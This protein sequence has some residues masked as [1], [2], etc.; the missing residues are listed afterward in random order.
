MGG[1]L[2]CSPGFGGSTEHQHTGTPHFHLQVHVACAYQF[3]TMTEIVEMIRDDFETA[4]SAESVMQYQAWLHREEPT[5]PEKHEAERTSLEQEWWQR[6]DNPR[7]NPLC[8]LPKYMT[9]D[10]SPSMWSDDVDEAA[11]RLEAK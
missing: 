2:R 7:H 8:T 1:I 10:T 11:A 9:D 3:A 4:M 5:N 6:Y